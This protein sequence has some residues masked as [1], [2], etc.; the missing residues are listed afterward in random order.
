LSKSQQL[1][2]ASW[3]NR[4]LEKQKVEKTENWQKSKLGK[5]QVG[6]RASWESRKL[7]KWQEDEMT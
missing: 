1:I 6:K 4:K 3:Q 7:T 2:K 5:Q